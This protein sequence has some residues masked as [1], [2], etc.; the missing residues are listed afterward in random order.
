MSK[1]TRQETAARALQATDM[2]ICRT[3]YKV[4]G[5][6]RGT[7][8]ELEHGCACNRSDQP[9]WD[10]G[11]FNERVTLCYGCGLELLRS[12]TRWSVWFC[13][14][15]KVR[16]I[17][18]NDLCGHYVIPIGR[19]SIMANRWQR[20]MALGSD[21][22]GKAEFVAGL[23]NFIE[24]IQLLG[25]HYKWIVEQNCRGTSLNEP[26]VWLIEY[27]LAADRSEAGKAYGYR[28]LL[29]RFEVPATVIMQLKE[30]FA[31]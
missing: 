23:N 27:L 10:V 8:Y 19:H 13:E 25:V 18:L 21:F 5:M 31:E 6:W 1:A 3:C 20:E 7:E 2:Q 16:T 29:D 26:E 12:G 9:R 24:R 22:S 4:Y 11:D 17:K 14:F 15:C 28:Q 30:E